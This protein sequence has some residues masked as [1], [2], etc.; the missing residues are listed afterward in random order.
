MKLLLVLL[1]L[2]LPLTA[3]DTITFVADQWPP[4]N[5]S[6]SDSAPGFVV[7][8]VQEIFE[9]EGFTVFYRNVPWSRVLLEVEG[10]KYTAAI[11]TSP[12]EFKN[13]VFP[14]EEIGVY[15]NYFFVR[16][17]FEWQFDGISSLRP[18][19]FSGVQDYSYGDEIMEYIEENRS[20]PRINLI[21]GSNTAE[22]SLQRLLL[23][24][25]DIYVEDKN[26]G[27]Y[28]VKKLGISDSVKI[29]GKQGAGVK[30]FVAFSPAQAQSPLY[31]TIFDAGIRSLR[32]S[33]RLAE[34]L[35]NYGLEDWK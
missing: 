34:I 28:T 12:E 11:G 6:P 20:S 17:E 18:H 25:V 30:L 22:R 7:E 21:T 1:L 26:V 27:L 4:Y 35:N 2:S 5:G 19:V 9:S 29:A 23:K 33:G 8:I 31:C 24:R 16:S 3:G 15:Y 32:K 10:G 13:G 14:E